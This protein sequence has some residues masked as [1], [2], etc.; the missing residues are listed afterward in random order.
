MEES[1]SVVV[2][3]V[4]EYI[5]EKE[6]D[7]RSPTYT[8]CFGVFENKQK[9]EH[10]VWS[11]FENESH[12]EGYVTW[13]SYEEFRSLGVHSFYYH[14]EFFGYYREDGLLLSVYGIEYHHLS[15]E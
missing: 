3:T 1:K 11:C 6:Y 9:A 2:V 15:I 5:V 12:W 14:D 13:M 8:P 7:F 4:L 10:A